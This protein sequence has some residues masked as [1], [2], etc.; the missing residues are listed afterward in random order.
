MLHDSL[1][2][3]DD[4]TGW[5]GVSALIREWRRVESVAYADRIIQPQVFECGRGARTSQSNQC[6][7]RVAAEKPLADHAHPPECCKH[8]G[9]QNVDQTREGVDGAREI[10]RQHVQANSSWTS[11]TSFNGWFRWRRSSARSVG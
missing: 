10:L 8:S 5:L 9:L 6:R 3:V 4:Q 2:E 11:S 1:A 7:R